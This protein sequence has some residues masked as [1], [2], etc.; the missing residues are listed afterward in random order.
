M[1]RRVWLFVV[2]EP[3]RLK[4]EFYPLRIGVMYDYDKFVQAWE[5]RPALGPGLVL[6][7]EDIEGVRPIRCSV[8]PSTPPSAFA[9]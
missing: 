6:T 1:S 8:S 4:I 9:A 7:E 2:L 5:A 3:G